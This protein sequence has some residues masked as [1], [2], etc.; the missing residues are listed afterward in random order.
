MQRRVNLE[1]LWT[2]GPNAVSSLGYRL[3][4]VYFRGDQVRVQEAPDALR[5]NITGWC[6]GQISTITA[7]GAGTNVNGAI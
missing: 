5:L 2:E 4:E 7:F 6:Y 1:T 3:S